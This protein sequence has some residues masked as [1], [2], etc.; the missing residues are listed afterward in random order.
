MTTCSIFTSI[1]ENLHEKIKTE[2]GVPLKELRR[3]IVK[4]KEKT[5]I[6]H[7]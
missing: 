6:G 1:E 7:N 5:M 3:E 4:S 2:I